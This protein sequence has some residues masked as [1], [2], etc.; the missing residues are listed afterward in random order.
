MNIFVNENPE[1]IALLRLGEFTGTKL[2]KCHLT[3]ILCPSGVSDGL[4]VER[5]SVLVEFANAKYVF[6]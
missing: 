5:F 6:S 2:L 3:D 4:S 1:K